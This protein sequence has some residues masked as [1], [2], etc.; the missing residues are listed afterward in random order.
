MCYFTA[1]PARLTRTAPNGDMSSSSTLGGDMKITRVTYCA[2]KLH[3]IPRCLRL[4]LA[5]FGYFGAGIMLQ[6]GGVADLV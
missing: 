6:R 1:M 4:P 2:D 5:S 3:A